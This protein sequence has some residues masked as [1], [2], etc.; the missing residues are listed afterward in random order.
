[1]GVD[2]GLRTVSASKC[3]YYDHSEEVNLDCGADTKQDLLLVCQGVLGGQVFDD[4]TDTALEGV[5]VS[6]T[7]DCEDLGRTFGPDEGLTATTDDEG[8]W[9]MLVPLC[10]D[11]GE[12]DA[13]WALTMSKDGYSLYEDGWVD[14]DLDG[15]SD[16]GEPGTEFAD[17]NGFDS[18][19]CVGIGTDNCTDAFCPPPDGCVELIDSEDYGDVDL[20]PNAYIQGR[21]FCDGLVSDNGLFDPGEEQPNSLV[22]LYRDTDED[23]N[24]DVFMEEQLSDGNGHYHFVIDLDANHDGVVTDDNGGGAD[25]DDF[26]VM[27]SPTEEAAIDMTAGE[28]RVIGI[29]LC[30]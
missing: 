23:G 20:S 12:A 28:N 29:D 5:E 8:Y 10:G 15:V 18:S 25:E 17:D 26:T 19:D 24:G 7:V 21:V 27:S 13:P 30:K 4:A 22:R 14:T 16:V 9:W 2:E 1:M 11:A 6:L 3:G